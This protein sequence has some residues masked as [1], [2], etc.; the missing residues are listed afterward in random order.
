MRAGLRRIRQKPKV[1]IVLTKS[2]EFD[3]IVAEENDPNGAESGEYD[4]KRMFH[5]IHLSCAFPAV[6][7]AHGGPVRKLCG[8]KAAA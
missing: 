3:T 6:P 1:E 7:T 2:A 8:N 5:M 4:G